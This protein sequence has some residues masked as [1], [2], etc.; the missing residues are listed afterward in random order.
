MSD[1][2]QLFRL[3]KRTGTHADVFAA[4][5]LADLLASAQDAGPVQRN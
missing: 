4:V 2:L 5:G 1:T 3:L